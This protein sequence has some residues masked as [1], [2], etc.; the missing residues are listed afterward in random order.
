MRT[1]PVGLASFVQEMGV[2]DYGQI[3]AGSVLSML[4]MFVLFALL[5][6]FIVQSLATS[7][8]KG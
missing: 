8:L 7:G 6:R 1:V 3:M 2:T 4:P 5:Q